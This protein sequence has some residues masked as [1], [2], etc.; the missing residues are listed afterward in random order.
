MSTIIVQK[1]G[2]FKGLYY[3]HKIFNEIENQIEMCFAL[4]NLLWLHFVVN[5]A[6]SNELLTLVGPLSDIILKIEHSQAMVL[7]I[8][9]ESSTCTYVLTVII[10]SFIIYSVEKIHT[11]ENPKKNNFH[12]YLAKDFIK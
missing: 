3:H 9:S 12:Y 7:I 5:S 6:W 1:V 10:F 4:N 11:I 8:S 2:W